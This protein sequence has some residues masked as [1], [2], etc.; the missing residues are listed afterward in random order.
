M[1]KQTLIAIAVILPVSSNVL[2]DAYK[3][4]FSSGRVGYQRTVCPKDA[5]Q[6]IVH[7]FGNSVRIDTHSRA[8]VN[9]WVAKLA[10]SRQKQLN[11]MRERSAKKKKFQEKMRTAA[12]TDTRD[13]ENCKKYT[14]LYE[15]RKKQQGVEVMD[16]MTGERSLDKSAAA[17]EMIS[18]TKDTMKFYCG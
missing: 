16:F 12:L 18:S 11:E 13:K 9:P 17:K 1:L 15:K 4:E 8:D 10:D 7:I 14:A 2:A 5:V 6:S 3:C